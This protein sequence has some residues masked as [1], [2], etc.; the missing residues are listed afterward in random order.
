VLATLLVDDVRTWLVRAF[1]QRGSL[2]LGG[3]LVSIAAFCFWWNA[4]KLFNDVP[5]KIVASGVYD[6]DH[7]QYYEYCDYL[8]GR[9]SENFTY[10]SVQ[11]LTNLGFQNRRETFEDQLKAW[12]DMIWVCHDLN[13]T[14]LPA[15]EEAWPL[16]D[17]P[18]G[19]TTLVLAHREALDQ[20][21]AVLSDVYPGLGD[22]DHVFVSQ[23][24]TFTNLAWEFESGDEL[25][26]LGLHAEYFPTGATTP[27]LSRIDMVHDLSWDDAGL[28]LSPPFDV[29]WRGVVY[30]EEEGNVRL[31]AETDD[32]VRVLIDGDVVY[33]T[34]GDQVT[35]QPR[36]L[37][38][39]WHAIE[40]ALE[41]Q[42][43]GGS[44]RLVWVDQA[45]LRV[46]VV[47]E[48]LFPL[49]TWNAWQHERTLVVP[50]TGE[51]F[52]THRIDL[53]PHR[54]LTSVLGTNAPV[55]PFALTVQERWSSVWQPPA[56]GRYVFSVHSLGGS[57]QL[58][59]DGQPVP[60]AAG[61]NQEVEAEVDVSA[62][63][64]QIELIQDI[65]ADP[66]QV[67][68]WAGFD[69]AL[70]RLLPGVDRTTIRAPTTLTVEPY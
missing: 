61:V 27:A 50:E 34:R 20:P 63:R 62:G 37:R 53:Q 12:G 47:D 40:I 14:A 38:A 25:T 33:S 19:R 70:Y 23:N 43:P 5:P 8:Q 59:V 22:P 6:G 42:S 16:R 64:H 54:S 9:G 13:G 17:L 52:V 41:K 66:A 68:Q 29:R 2:V 18:F 10:S 58:L 57:V 31:E 60:L 35:A 36:L 46:P 30:V 21:L 39:G 48:D 7:D 69:L 11:A 28:P 44:V 3:V 49:S 26:R 55:D 51:R 15:A 24:G 32:P 45:G 56:E 4:D 67:P 65:P 1:G